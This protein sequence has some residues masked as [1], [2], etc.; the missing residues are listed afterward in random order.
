MTKTL[1]DNTFA[2]NPGK[3]TISHKKL[4]L[5][6]PDLYGLRAAIVR[7]G[8][9]VNGHVPALVYLEEHMLYGDSRAAVVLSTD[10]LLV[11]AYTDEFDCVALLRFPAK[12]GETCSPRVGQWLLTVNTYKRQTTRDADLVMGPKMMDRWS[13]FH[14]IIA[15]FISDDEARIASRIEEIGNE[16]FQRALALG[17]AYV[18]QFP[19]RAR[20][21]RPVYAQFPAGSRTFPD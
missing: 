13:G 12:I 2:T 6:H 16:E 4:R 3:I 17:K 11:A 21:G 10:P 1:D 7:W 14:P 9:R 5:L 18:T 15:D 19:G 8:L 20:D